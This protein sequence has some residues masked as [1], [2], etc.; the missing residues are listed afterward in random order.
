MYNDTRL[1]LN[2]R[3]APFTPTLWKLQPEN[4]STKMIQVW[5]P[6]VHAS[7]GGGDPSHGLSDISLAWMVDRVM[8]HTD[9]ECDL[10]YLVKCRQKFSPNPMKP[11][12][13]TEPFP[14][15]FRGIYLV[16]GS[17]PRTPNKY[18]SDE[19]AKEGQK[20]NEYIHKS[21]TERLEKLG[22]EWA[23]PELQNLPEDTFGEIEKKLLW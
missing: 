13:G 12:W 22:N 11:A 7:C 8:T 2:E 15:S 21:V 3:R 16:A 23:H 5:F 6:G 9:L 14:E 19:E 20:T 10:D 1:A 17:K 18:L 4:K